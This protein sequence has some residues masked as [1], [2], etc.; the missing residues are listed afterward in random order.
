MSDKQSKDEV[1]GRRNALGAVGA[2]VAAPYV[3]GSQAR[4]QAAWPT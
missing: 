4:A 3:I 1:A 2:I